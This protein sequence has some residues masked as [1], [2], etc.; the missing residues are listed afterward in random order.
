MIGFFGATPLLADPVAWVDRCLDEVAEQEA[1]GPKRGAFKERECMS[2]ILN[3]CSFADPSESCFEGL[4]D[5]FSQRAA[6]IIATLPEQVS[7]TE[8]QKN[9]YG[10]RLNA[11]KNVKTTLQCREDMDA[12]ACDARAALYQYS[13]A[14]GLPDLVT[15]IEKL[16]LEDIK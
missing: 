10:R 14:T 15:R 13:L 4:V 2:I 11:I 9:I 16:E 1:S 8:I 5:G 6:Q 3:Y 12:L 7:G